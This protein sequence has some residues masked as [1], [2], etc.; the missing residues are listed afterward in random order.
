M[1]F[2]IFFRYLL[3]F[4]MIIPAVIF[5][6][7]PVIKYLKINSR[8]DFFI[9]GIL[10]LI[11]IFAAAYLALLYSFRVRTILIPVLILLFV[12]YCWVVNLSFTKKIFCFFN[13]LM[14]CA[15]S[16]FFTIT[17]MAPKEIQNIIWYKT[18]LF[19]LQSSIACLGLEFISGAFFFRTLTKKIPTLLNEELLENTWNYL[20]LIPLVMAAVICWMAPINPPLMIIGRIRPI[21]IVLIIFVL[22]AVFMFYE[23]FWRITASL[24]KSAKLQ[25]ENNLLQMESKRY[26]ELKHYMN[27]TR[28]LCHDFRQHIAVLSEFARV[29]NIDKILDY[30]QQLTEGTRNYVLFCA[31]NAVDAVA[32]HYDRL[33]K[34]RGIKIEWRL[35]LP[36]VLPINESD[37]CAMFGNLIENAL[38]AVENLENKTIRNINVISLMLSEAMLGISIDNPFEGELKFNHDGLPVSSREGHGLGLISVSNIIERYSGSLKIKTDDKIF[39]VDIILY[40]NA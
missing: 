25:Q 18:R 35:E 31:N 38:N 21:S 30:T 17:L 15:W 6:L 32:S 4:S 36:A 33:A 2:E 26:N 40:C 8:R 9:S 37:Y 12:I 34:K 16:N 19:M 24:T 14:L 7:L 1:N 22:F 27:E 3:E 11:L 29:G 39:K 13:S 10:I 5:A 23:I 20:C 28:A